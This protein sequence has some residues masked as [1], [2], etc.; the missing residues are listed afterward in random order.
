MLMS[1]KMVGSLKEQGVTF[2]CSVANYTLADLFN[3][4]HDA[5][6]FTVLLPILLKEIA[7]TD[8]E[9]WS[10]LDKVFRARLP[11][12]IVV[13]NFGIWMVPD[14]RL[15]A[16]SNM[17]AVYT[18]VWN[19]YF[20]AKDSYYHEDGFVIDFVRDILSS[21]IALEALRGKYLTAQLFDKARFRI[22]IAV[23]K[24]FEEALDEEIAKKEKCDISG[25][26]T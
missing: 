23:V 14:S 17:A 20:W 9:V 6:F 5:K 2:H 1:E 11:K 15:L 3:L 25:L 26:V 19:D 13:P 12:K 24:E 7:V 10:A 4:I 8:E 21:L 22:S 18:A 16:R